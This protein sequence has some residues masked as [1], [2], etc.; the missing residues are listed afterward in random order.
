MGDAQNAN[1]IDSLNFVQ[2]LLCMC[3]EDNV[4]YVRIRSGLVV[5]HCDSD[6]LKPTLFWED[7]SQPGDT[8]SIYTVLP[9]TGRV[10]VETVN[11]QDARNQLVVKPPG[12]ILTYSISLVTPGSYK[13]LDGS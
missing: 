13:V 6:V 12:T 10:G 8:V 9:S 4:W 7:V 1:L 3:L 5:E 11:G 2:Q